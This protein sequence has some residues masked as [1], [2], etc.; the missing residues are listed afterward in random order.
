[1]IGDAHTVP[2]KVHGKSGS[3]RIRMIPAPR[4]TGIV[5]APASKKV[6]QFS[7]IGDVYT[8]SSGCTRTRGNFVKATYYCLENTYKYSTPD[9]WGAPALKQ[10]PY[11]EHQEFLSTP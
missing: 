2:C 3:V 8:S 6:I 9:W 11:D 10:H 5:A 1:M 4:G 7:G